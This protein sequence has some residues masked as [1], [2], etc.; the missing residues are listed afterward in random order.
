MTGRAEVQVL[1]P[2][3]TEVGNSPRRLTGG[4]S[5]TQTAV[6]S[7]L[8]TEASA[9]PMSPASQVPPT[10]TTVSPRAV[11]GGGAAAKPS[12]VWTDCLTQAVL[13]K[14]QRGEILCIKGSHNRAELQSAHLRDDSRAMR[15]LL[16]FTLSRD[17]CSSFTGEGRTGGTTMGRAVRFGDPPAPEAG[18]IGPGTYECNLDAALAQKGTAV[19][20]TKIPRAARRLQKEAEDRAGIP[21][22]GQY[23]WDHLVC[24]ARESKRVKGSMV[25]VPASA[26]RE[27]A[28]IDLP[29]TPSPQ[30]NWAPNPRLGGRGSRGFQMDPTLPRFAKLGGSPAIGPGTYESEA[31][32]KRQVR[33]RSQTARMD[34]CGRDPYSVYCKNDLLRAQLSAGPGQYEAPTCFRSRAEPS[35]FV[36]RVGEVRRRRAESAR[37]QSRSY[38]GS[39]TCEGRPIPA[40]PSSRP[41]PAGNRPPRSSVRP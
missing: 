28:H 17:M 13:R 15:R 19:R 40:P 10:V 27:L 22:V 30:E 35:A 25:P 34:G 4:T 39:A 1:S 16:A 3:A 29:I 18:D 20:S 7:P 9:G 33:K 26:V 41:P 23:E 6:L 21:G 8:G 38:G 2:R 31:S 11:G 36:K 5:H 37:P 14:P 32:Y 24:I 12:A